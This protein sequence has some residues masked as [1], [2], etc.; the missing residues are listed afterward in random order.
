M[1]QVIVFVGLKLLQVI[2]NVVLH[3]RTFYTHT[4]R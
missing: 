3:G 2:F 4:L 1:I